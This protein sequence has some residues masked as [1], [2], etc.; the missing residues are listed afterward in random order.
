MVLHP[1]GSGWAQR[2]ERLDH[3]LAHVRDR[4]GIW[5]PTASACARYWEAIYPKATHLKLEPS[6]WADYPGSL[7]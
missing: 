3:F 7:S 2:A 1:Q 4:P 6:I 5:N